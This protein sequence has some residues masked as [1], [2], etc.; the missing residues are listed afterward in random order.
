MKRILTAIAAIL[1]IGNCLYAGNPD[2]RGE[3]GANEL[4]MN[5]WGRSSGLWSMNTADI[6]GIESERLNPAGLAFTNKTEIGA[7][8]TLWLQGSGVGV[9]HFGIAQKV[10]DNAFS[11]SFQALNLGTIERTTTANPE[12]G[13]GRFHSSLY[14]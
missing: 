7:S 6:Q 1:L 14:R 10:K 13:L 8:Y 12:G 4:L 3:A 9:A 5:G 11:L 2:R